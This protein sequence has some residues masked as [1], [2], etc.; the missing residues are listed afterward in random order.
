MKPL[1]THSITQ[2]RGHL[3][4]MAVYLLVIAATTP[5]RK[6]VSA[7]R[8]EGWYF[9]VYR[10]CKVNDFMKRADASTLDATNR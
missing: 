6:M 4:L 2:N 1:G 9:F 10:A 5:L 8:W 7:S 3:G